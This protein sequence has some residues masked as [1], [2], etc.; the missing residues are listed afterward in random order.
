[1]PPSIVNVRMP[2]NRA[3]GP[4]AWPDHCRSSPIAAPPSV[5][6]RRPVRDARLTAARIS[7]LPD[8]QNWTPRLTNDVMCRRAEHGQVQ[9]PAA[10][11]PH[12]DEVRVEIRGLSKHFAIGSSLF[13]HCGHRAWNLR[14]V[15]N[16]VAQP[17]QR[18][19]FRRRANAI[20]VEVGSHGVFTQF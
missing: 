18:L 3:C 8:D 1:M 12:H 5:A 20:D 17:P 9:G 19:G 16:K 11:Y 14:R 7:A 4:L 6:T 15:W 10:V 13:D 2:P